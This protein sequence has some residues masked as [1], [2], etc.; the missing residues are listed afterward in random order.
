[1]DQ[2]DINYENMDQNLRSQRNIKVDLFYCRPWCAMNIYDIYGLL[3]ANK[4]GFLQ[5]G[6]AVKTYTYYLAQGHLVRGEADT[7]RCLLVRWAIKYTLVGYSLGN[8]GNHTGLLG[9]MD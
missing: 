8:I 1:M 2:N 3:T 7:L 4:T 6:V 5:G 9:I